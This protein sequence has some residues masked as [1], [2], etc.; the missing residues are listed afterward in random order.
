MNAGDLV[1]PSIRLVRILGHGGMGSVWV[2]EHERLRTEVVVKFIVGEY[3]THPEA[4]ARFEREAT[5]AAQAKS[6]HVVQVFDHGISQAGLPYIAMELLEGEDLASCIRREKAIGAEVFAEWFRQAASGLSRAHK[7]G[8]V[9]RDIKP[10]NIFLC[11]EDDDVLVKVLDF[12]IAKSDVASTSFSGTRT[13]AMLGTAYYMS[14]E[15][16]MGSKAI[17]LRADLWAM[18]VVAYYSLTGVRPFDGEAIGQLVMAITQHPIVPPSHHNAALSPAIDSWM[19]KALARDPAERFSSAKE[20]SDALSEAVF[21]RVPQRRASLSGT[22]GTRPSEAPSPEAPPREATRG[23]TTLS[24]AASLVPRS[25]PASSTIWLTQPLRAILMLAGAA[26]FIVATAFAWDRLQRTQDAEPSPSLHFEPPPVSQADARLA[27]PRSDKDAAPLASE[28]E[29]GPEPQ[30]ETPKQERP[31]THPRPNVAPKDRRSATP[32]VPAREST[33]T[34]AT[35]PTRTATPTR[36]SASTPTPTPARAS[37]PVAG[38][39]TKAAP[40]PPSKPAPAPKPA[41]PLHMAIE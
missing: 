19:Q 9:H 10:E 28:P 16:T 35:T 8:I 17:D 4:L 18:G 25:D 30:P 36:T 40:P 23:A 13:G 24:P 20:M 29:P 26:G 7:K 38:S 6:P 32:P 21:G 11:H 12:G 39:S 5:L 1:T 41:T 27:D 15:Q 2:A 37:T 3:A 22:G 31:G 14:P 33:P 34:R